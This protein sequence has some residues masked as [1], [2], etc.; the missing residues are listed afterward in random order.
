VNEE[1]ERRR[2]R[3]ELTV[4]F[5]ILVLWLGVSFALWFEKFD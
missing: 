4:A 2:T 1:Q 5:G 3:F